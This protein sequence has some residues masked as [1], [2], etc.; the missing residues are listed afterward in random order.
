MQSWKGLKSTRHLFQNAL[1]TE[2]DVLPENHIYLAF[3][4][5]NKRACKGWG[6]AIEHAYT[7][8]DVMHVQVCFYIDNV[9]LTYSADEVQHQVHMVHEKKWSRE[10]WEFYAIP[11]NESVRAKMMEEANR[12][13]GRPYNYK[14]MVNFCCLPLAPDNKKHFSCAHY[15]MCILQAGG[16][17]VGIEPRNISDQQIKELICG[18]ET[19]KYNVV[20]EN[21]R[22]ISQSDNAFRSQ[23][24]NSTEPFN[25][26]VEAVR[27]IEQ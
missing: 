3:L 10:G 11:L 25:F 9:F 24:A 4:K 14:V 16:L 20:I 15:T 27:H 23:I 22:V 2:D 18:I 19:T 12:H 13:L 6:P 1:L 26:Y 5:Y 17:F 7:G 8:G 21:N